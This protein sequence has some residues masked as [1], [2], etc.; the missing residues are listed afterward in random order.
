MALAAF[1]VPGPCAISWDNKNLGNTKAGVV[2]RANT[3]WESI[4]DDRHA[5]APASYIFT[6]KSAVVEII[7]LQSAYVKLAKPWASGTLLGANNMEGTLASDLAKPLIITEAADAG[8]W[9]ALTAV[10]EDPTVLALLSTQELQIPIRF[11]LL[12]DDNGRL[13]NTVPAYIGG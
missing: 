8:S 7:A 10:P 9:I 5:T 12:L 4:T 2:I 3:A 13:F 6:G 1:H 11:L